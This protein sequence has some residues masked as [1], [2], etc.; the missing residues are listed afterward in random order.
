MCR[1]RPRPRMGPEQFD[2]VARSRF[3]RDAPE[4][5][6]R[7]PRTATT[8]NCRHVARRRPVRRFGHRKEDGHV[9]APASKHLELID[10]AIRRSRCRA[11][12]AAGRRAYVSSDIGNSTSASTFPRWE[13]KA[14]GFRGWAVG[15]LRPEA[16]PPDKAPASNEAY[17][18]KL[19]RPTLPDRSRM[20]GG[21]ATALCGHAPNAV[22]MAP[23]IW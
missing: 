9:A 13:T 20:V 17:A 11:P 2:H 8:T 16:H 15:R 19:A 23:T 7:F 6:Q 22:G 18:R 12:A 21:M 5:K 10:I 14:S 1:S 3:S 4:P